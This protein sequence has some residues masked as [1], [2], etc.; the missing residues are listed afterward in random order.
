MT[1]V[2]TQKTTETSASILPLRNFLPVHFFT[3]LQQTPHPFTNFQQPFGCV[4]IR[5][6]LVVT[7]ISNGRL[8]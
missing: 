3:L 7:G 8:I 2:E 6:Q 1:A 4:Q 5:L